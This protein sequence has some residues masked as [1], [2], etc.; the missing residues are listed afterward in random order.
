MAF[1]EAYIF[2]VQTV[3]KVSQVDGQREALFG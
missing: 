2:A 3:V 1:I